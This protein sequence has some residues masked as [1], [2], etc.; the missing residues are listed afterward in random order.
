VQRPKG[1]RS[2]Q[3]DPEFVAS[4]ER[5]ITAV[6]I[7]AP[8]PRR[9]P[10]PAPLGCCSFRVS[11]NTSPDLTCIDGDGVK[12]FNWLYLQVTEAV[13]NRVAIGGL[14]DT[15]WL[16]ELDFQFARL[17]FDALHSALTGAPCPG[18]WEAMFSCRGENRIARIPCALAGMN[19]HINHDLPVAI[20]ATCKAKLLTLHHCTERRSTTPTR[21]S[22]R[23]LIVSSTR[24]SKR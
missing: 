4:R 1:S 5:G 6:M 9:K 21:T 3:V 17:Y 16:A 19:A 11:R 15:A 23:R 14:N 13:G 7:G 8:V 24:L 20:V 18:C 12:W 10:Q 22:I 2:K